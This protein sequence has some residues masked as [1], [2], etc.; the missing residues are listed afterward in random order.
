MTPE[1][2][3]QQEVLIA[4]AELGIS[5]WRNNVGALPDPRTGRLI[6]F[7]LANESA[8][9]NARLKSSDLIGLRR[10][11]VTQD[12]VGATIGQFCSLELKPP[13]WT[14]SGTPRE[15]AQLA[16]IEHVRRWGGFACFTTGAEDL[17][18]TDSLAR[19]GGNLTGASP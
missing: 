2:R 3:A 9:L 8:A 11:V 16:W 15:R 4:C 19:L 13:G 7:G 12:L 17:T 10:V 5:P 6:R 18:L 1:Q 14:Y